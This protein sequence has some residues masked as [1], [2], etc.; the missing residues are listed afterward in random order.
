[1]FATG[2]TEINLEDAKDPD[3]ITYLT[4]HEGKHFVVLRIRPPERQEILAWILM[5]AMFLLVLVTWIAILFRGRI[6]KWMF[7]FEVKAI[8]WQL[9]FLL[10]PAS[11]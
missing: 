10:H 5:S 4:P 1:M 2:K 11:N 7:D 6:P 9:S 3:S 8:G